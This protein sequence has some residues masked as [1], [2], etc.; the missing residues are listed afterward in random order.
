MKKIEITD[1][2][3][4]ENDAILRV[5]GKP[6]YFQFSAGVEPSIEV[7]LEYLSRQKPSPR[8]FEEI[9]GVA[10]AVE[11]FNANEV[12]EGSSPFAD[13]TAFDAEVEYDVAFDAGYEEGLMSASPFVNPT[14][15]DGLSLNG[16]DGWVAGYN[17]GVSSAHH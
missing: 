14:A 8:E 7:A 3:M 9:A 11:D 17:A 12:V 2:D 5:G 10:Q 13:D 16:R 15:P 4:F 1:I 6:F